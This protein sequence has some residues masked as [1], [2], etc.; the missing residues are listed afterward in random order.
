[1]NTL[2]IDWISGPHANLQELLANGLEHFRFSCIFLDVHLRRSRRSRQK[3]TLR[4]AWVEILIAK[5][6]LAVVSIVTYCC[7]RH[8]MRQLTLKH[9]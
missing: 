9:V 3:R 6:T 5:C 2:L 7:S 1:M 8:H 4:W